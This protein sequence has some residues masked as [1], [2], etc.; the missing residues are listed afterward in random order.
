MP[1]VFP[2]CPIQVE[3]PYF[4]TYDRKA[5]PIPSKPSDKTGYEPWYMAVNRERYGT[6][7][8]TPE[9]W[10]EVMATYYGMILRLG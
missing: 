10:A 1:L 4:S 5:T 7:R 6:H 8:A 2:L 9:I 3:E